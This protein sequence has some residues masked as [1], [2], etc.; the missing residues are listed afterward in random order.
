MRRNKTHCVAIDRLGAAKLGVADAD[1][2]LQ[3]S[4]EPRLRVVAPNNQ[5]R[6]VPV[7]AE[8]RR[9]YLTPAEMEKLIAVAKRG[10]YGQRVGDIRKLARGGVAS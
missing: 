3:H 4:G 8:R 2:L 7:I 5:N 9:E 10:R 6:T 1:G